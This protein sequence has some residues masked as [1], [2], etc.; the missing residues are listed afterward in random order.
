MRNISIHVRARIRAPRCDRDHT[1]NCAVTATH[2]TRRGFARSNPARGSTSTCRGSIRALALALVVQ[3][4]AAPERDD[5][6]CPAPGVEI[7]TRQPSS[8]A[9]RRAPIR[10]RPVSRIG[11][12]GPLTVS[13]ENT[14]KRASIWSARLLCSNPAG[15]M[16]WPFASGRTPAS[17]QCA[18][19]RLRHGRWETSGARYLLLTARTSDFARVAH[20]GTHPYAKYHAA[21]FELMR[22]DRAR[23]AE[24][25]SETARLAR[26]H[27]LP[28]WRAVGAFLEGL[29]TAECGAL[30]R[31]SATCAASPRAGASKA[32]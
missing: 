9:L 26:E 2:L 30:A 16:I 27:D 17:R 29:A 11:S 4:F 13:P 24:N 23:A 19:W 8:L 28:L 3:L 18:T 20:I 6:L 21:M 22:G 31:G 1:V 7:D 32:S 5:D 10:P 15:T 25:G 14:P 12:S